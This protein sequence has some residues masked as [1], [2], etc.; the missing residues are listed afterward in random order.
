MGVYVTANAIIGIKTGKISGLMYDYC[1]KND[2]N[3]DDLINT[4]EDNYC[5]ITEDMSSDTSFIG[6]VLSILS[7]NDNGDIKSFDIGELD[8]IRAL[9][10]SK[11]NDDPFIQ[12]LINEGEIFTPEDIK[13]HIFNTHN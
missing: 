9:A 1:D 13:L 3:C 6:I 8:D 11:I 5:Y 7:R 2:I 10:F 12:V 4:D